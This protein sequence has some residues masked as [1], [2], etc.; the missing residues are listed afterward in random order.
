MA[1]RIR[2]AALETRTARLKL[3]VRKKP[4]AFAPFA[5]G[6]S[7]LPRTWPLGCA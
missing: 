2:S 1:R 5:P 7:P 6:L 3:P 4:H